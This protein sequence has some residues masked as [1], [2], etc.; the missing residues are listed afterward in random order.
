MNPLH[1][2]PDSEAP[3]AA[4]ISPARRYWRGILLGLLIF[5]CGAVTGGAVTIFVTA[6]MVRHTIGH[7]EGMA[8]QVASGL[9]KQYNLSP[10]QA[11]Q[12]EA[13]IARHNEAV[14]N[15][16]GAAFAQ[17]QKEI[18]EMKE[19]VARVLG[20]EHARKWREAIDRDFLRVPRHVTSHSPQP[21]KP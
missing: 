1:P 18:G 12:I 11:A 7:P 13:I 2:T 15:A 4:A 3:K 21:K 10:E 5:L 6:R 14:M 8:H 16:R 20:E 19:E 9:T 17:M